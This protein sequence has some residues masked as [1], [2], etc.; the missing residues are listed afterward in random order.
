LAL[1]IVT[2]FYL[3]IN[4]PVAS[5]I[6][7]IM[8]MPRIQII[9]DAVR[10]A[11][12]LT[13]PQELLWSTFPRGAC[14]DASLVLGRTFHDFGIDCFEYVRGNKYDADGTWASS[15]TWLKCGK[16]IVDITADQFPDVDTSVI[17]P[18]DSDWHRGWVEDAPTASTLLAYGDQVPQL[19]QLL[20]ILK[21]RFGEVGL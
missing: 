14:G 6:I 16:W 2:F 18:K 5:Y 3:K 20:S 10:R 13:A 11:I 8:D 9:A 12:D 21:P 4:S 7:S 17:V 15:H 19:W 1:T